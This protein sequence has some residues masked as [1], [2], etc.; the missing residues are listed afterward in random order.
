L[1][2]CLFVCF[3]GKLYMCDIYV[4]V[5]ASLRSPSIY[6]LQQYITWNHL[7]LRKQSCPR[8]LSPVSVPAA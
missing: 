5:T 7:V 8:T 4:S 2:V 6:T 1:F 3:Q